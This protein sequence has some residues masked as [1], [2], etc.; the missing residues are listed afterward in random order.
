MTPQ[1]KSI[2]I[3]ALT[4]LPS[5][6]CTRIDTSG[7]A[8]APEQIE[9]LVVFGIDTSGSFASRWAEHD[10]KTF[11]QIMQRLF[12]A[13]RGSNGTKIVFM[14]ISGTKATILWE[15]T[16]YRLSQ[17]FPNRDDLFAH[18][19]RHSDPKASR[20]REGIGHIVEYVNRKA[21]LE[22]ADV[23]IF[24]F[25]DGHDTTPRRERKASNKRLTAALHVY[26]GFFGMYGLTER[27]LNRWTEALRHETIQLSPQQWSLNSQFDSSPYLRSFE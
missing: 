2:A 5:I 7:P 23:S 15:G 6:S 11:D 20:I 10:G 18:C 26:Q 25:T 8:V 24:I 16:P 17:E 1:T 9:R 22:Q 13:S 19:Q 12:R 4:I 3:L 27:E 14:P 21:G